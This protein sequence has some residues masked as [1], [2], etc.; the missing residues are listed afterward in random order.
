MKVRFGKQPHKYDP[1]SLMMD[2]FIE[3]KELHIPAKHDFDHR[4]RPFPARTWGNDAYG[5]SVFAAQMDQLMR[6]ERVEQRLTMDTTDEDVIATYKALTGCRNPDDVN[7]IGYTMLD[8]LRW[9]KNE[10]WTLRSRNYK[11]DAYGEL[12][13]LDT[14]Q[15]RQSIFL[16]RGVQLGLWLP[17]TAAPQFQQ[18]FWDVTNKGNDSEPGSWGGLAVLAKRYDEENIFVLAWGIEIQVSNT[19]V[20]KYCD[21]AW[22]V[23]D[24]LESWRKQPGIETEKLEKRLKKIQGEE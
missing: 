19:F 23:V 13:P 22:A 10:G 8:A 9:W 14:R 7:D 3:T 16:L 12:D 21:E 5:N 20:A 1:R 6:M 2:E 15:L 17:R 24:S 18:G 11:I 4:R